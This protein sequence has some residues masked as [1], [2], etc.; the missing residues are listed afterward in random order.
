MRRVVLTI[1]KV[2]VAIAGFAFIVANPISGRGTVAFFISVPV[3]LLCFLLWKLLIPDADNGLR[4]V[5]LVPVLL[6]LACNETPKASYS[7]VDAAAQ[8]GAFQ[9]GWLPDVLRSDVSDIREIHNL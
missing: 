7:T 2:V 5:W 9:R 6:S 4:L 1:A 8:D 3:L